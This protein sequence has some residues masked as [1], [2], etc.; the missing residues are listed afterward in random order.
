MVKI[1]RLVAF[2]CSLT[3]GHGLADC[4]KENGMEG[5]IPSVQAWPF[6]V[7][8]H[9]KVAID[10]QGIPGGSNKEIFQKIRNYEFKKG[11]C[12]VVLWSYINRHCSIYPDYVDR[13]GPWLKSTRSKNWIKHLFND[14]DATLDCLMY[15]EHARLYLNTKKIKHNTYFADHFMTIPQPEGKLFQRVFDDFARD[16]KHPGA[17]T[18]RAFAQQVITD[19]TGPAVYLA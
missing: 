8:S 13:Y 10:N 9:F 2:G 11:D 15:D 6:L 4:Y 18:Q 19:S 5:P 1:K 3:Y 17:A 12:A 7:A 16:G 14:H